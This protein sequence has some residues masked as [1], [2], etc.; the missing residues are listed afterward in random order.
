VSES[1]SEL[2]RWLMSRLVL[3]LSVSEGVVSQFRRSA[4][5]SREVL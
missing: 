2:P 4:E 3:S 5:K 1:V